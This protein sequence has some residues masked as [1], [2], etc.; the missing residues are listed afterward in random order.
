MSNEAL[1]IKELSIGYR[2]KGR[3]AV[4]AS[5]I[6]VSLCKGELVALIGRNG[7]G[8]STLMRTLS[9][10]Q[11]P[12]SG[13]ITYDGHSIDS[14]AKELARKVSVVLTTP[15][16][17]DITAYDL[18]SLG[19]TPYTNF[20]GQMS[21]R[22]K[23]AVVKAMKIMGIEEL[24]ERNVTTLSDGERQKCMIAKSLAQETPVMLLDEPTSFL[25]FPS[26]VQ[27]F[28]TLKELARKHSKAILVSTHD[29]ELALRFAERIWLMHNNRLVVGTVEELSQ[30]GSLDAFISN[31]DICY[32][33]KDN[34]IEITLI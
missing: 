5:G 19:R 6:N 4:I 15:V 24:A 10:Y 33:I 16:S 32:N 3:S 34:R 17:A 8:K 20:L 14:S 27:L 31:D 12:L 29:M 23:D 25:D 11:K 7:A 1:Y 30:N 22:D 2:E 26:K 9:A 21:S 28:V 13:K 18:V